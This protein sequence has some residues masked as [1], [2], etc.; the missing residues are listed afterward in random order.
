MW[1]LAFLRRH[2]EQK[3]KVLGGS[4]CP[5]KNAKSHIA[6]KC[7]LDVQN[8]T[9]K[10]KNRWNSVNH[11][12]RTQSVW[13]LSIFD[14]I[15]HVSQYFL[16]ESLSVLAFFLALFQTP[17]VFLKFKNF[18]K[19]YVFFPCVF[20]LRGAK[21]K[22]FSTFPPPPHGIL[23]YPSDVFENKISGFDMWGI[24]LQWDEEQL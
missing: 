16:F 9:F 17:G 24:I 19:L 21:S 23:F 1:L 22:T 3:F 15:T 6:K 10:Q 14:S 5:R 11:F 7:P 4:E 8:S 20:G 12:F 2:S 18:A 13:F